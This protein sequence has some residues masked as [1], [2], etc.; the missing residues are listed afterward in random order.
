MSMYKLKL[1]DAAGLAEATTARSTGEMRIARHLVEQ[2]LARETNAFAVRSGTR[3]QAA[4]LRFV[5]D[6]ELADDRRRARSYGQLQATL[7]VLQKPPTCDLWDGLAAS[8]HAARQE[9][10]KA[11]VRQTPRRKNAP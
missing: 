1:L 10:A 8:A 4:L 11:A 6:T 5:R 3:L 7:R 9:V 2:L